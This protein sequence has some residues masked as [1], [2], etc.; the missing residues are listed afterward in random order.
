MRME[1]SREITFEIHS[2]QDIENAV[3]ITRQEYHK[4]TAPIRY[5]LDGIVSLFLELL[6][7]IGNVAKNTDEERYILEVL[8]ITFRRVIA[9]IILLESGLPQEAHMVLRN[10]LEWI[11][12]AIDITY[13]KTSLKEWEKTSQY[14]VTD[15]EEW[16]F[17]PSKTFK[18]IDNNEGNIYPELDRSF[19]QHT[20]KEWINISNK[21]VH[22]HSHSQIKNLFNSTGTF[23]FL[24]RKT[25]DK[26]KSNFK[27]YQELIVDIV[28]LLIGIPK[29]RDL[30]GKTEALTVQRD[31]FARNY[32][33]ITEE[34]RTTGRVLSEPPIPS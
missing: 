2:F 25:I 32:K 20:Y 29:Y 15:Q 11:L 9:S 8:I 30:I 7:L 14:D 12:I 5:L 23:Q 33:K 31:S 21:S 16:Y 3:K 6:D 34:L 18:R 22:A 28:S 24:G 17:K 10:A 27:M 13:N 1:S 26:Y 19:A 4:T